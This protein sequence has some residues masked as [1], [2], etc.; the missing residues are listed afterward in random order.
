MFIVCFSPKTTCDVSNPGMPHQKCLALQV[1]HGPE[2]QTPHHV[3]VLP[4]RDRADQNPHQA[5]R[6]M[7]NLQ[8]H[9]I[10]THS[11]Y[12][13]VWKYGLPLTHMF[14]P[15]LTFHAFPRIWG[16][17]YFPC[18]WSPK[19]GCT[20]EWNIPISN[21]D[22]FGV[23]PFLKTPRAPRPKNEPV[24]DQRHPYAG[25][26]SN[27]WHFD[28]FICHIAISLKSIEA[29]SN[30]AK[31]WSCG[32]L[33]KIPGFVAL[34]IQNEFSKKIPWAAHWDS[35]DWFKGTFAGKKKHISLENPWFFCRFSHQS[36]ESNQDVDESINMKNTNPSTP[37]LNFFWEILWTAHEDPSILLVFH[38]FPWFSKSQE[39]GAAD[40]VLP[41]TCGCASAGKCWYIYIYK[42][43]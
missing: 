37:S 18:F 2:H 23:P 35:M 39:P 31:L 34:I 36:I 1:F 21:S 13:F 4:P 42:C 14:T 28:S 32:N 40:L 41:G 12:E 29:V 17:P 9:H 20:L 30:S 26:F 27:P 15:N 7:A 16:F 8:H 6:M 5:R 25:G 3:G 24:D 33:E 22:D 11:Q 19:K 38:G 43:I 10:T